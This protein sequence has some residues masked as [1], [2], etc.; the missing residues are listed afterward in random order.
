MLRSEM[1]NIKYAIRSIEDN[2]YVFRIAAPDALDESY[3]NCVC[4]ISLVDNFAVTSA[5]MINDKIFSIVYSLHTPETKAVVGKQELFN[6]LNKFCSET[7]IKQ[8]DKD[9][10]QAYC[11]GKRLRGV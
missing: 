10:E 8:I 9:L 11:I 5:W 7:V 2:E 4:S 6:V 3:C 1:E